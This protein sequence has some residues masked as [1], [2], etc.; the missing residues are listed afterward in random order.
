MDKW[1]SKDWVIRAISLIL[2]FVL[3]LMVSQPTYP[4]SVNRSSTTIR[5]IEVE[6]RMNTAKY[7]LLSGED[8]VDLTFVGDKNALS[9]LP[10]YRVFVDVR[11]LTEGKHSK[12]PVR[13]E[14]L[15][16]NVQVRP[17]PATVSVEIAEK[18]AKTVPV[19]L[20]T[21]GAVAAGY[22]LLP[23]T[24][25][26]STVRVS[27]IKQEVEKVSSITAI[28]NVNNQKKTA[29]QTVSLGVHSKTN[30]KPKVR[31]TPVEANV[32]IPVEQIP[33]IVEPSKPEPTVSYRDIPIQVTVSKPPPEGY[34]VKSITAAPA[35]VR[36]YGPID[37]LKA[38]KTYPAGSVDL[39][40][41]TADTTFTQTI[42]VVAPAEKVAPTKVEIYVKMIRT[43]ATG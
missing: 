20:V 5:D 11:Y 1:F 27:G 3:W 17:N 24:Y 40:N 18:T 37:K 23:I 30:S 32:T 36:V 16:A 7:Q 8:K 29:K 31:V 10:A 39:S 26:P 4:F 38:L 14:G 43:P 12:V 41:V 13:V 15:P 25:T 34:E 6:Y 35:K 33:I 22:R 9:R 2:A 28:V 42:K 19:T 21:R